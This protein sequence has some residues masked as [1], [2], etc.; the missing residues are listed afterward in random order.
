MP[1]SSIQRMF[2]GTGTR[3]AGLG[4]PQ[5]G[6]GASV[7]SA[8]MR[9]GESRRAEAQKKEDKYLAAMDVDPVVYMSNKNTERQAQLLEEYQKD[10]Q[11]LLKQR[12]N[13]FKNFTTQDWV[14]L[15]QKRRVLEAEQERMTVDLKKFEA[16]DKIMEQDRAGK[17]QFD[18][19]EWV[20]VK[21]QYINEGKFPDNFVLPI[22]AKSFTETIA[23][24]SA[25]VY[26]GENIGG[27]EELKIG[28]VPHKR[29]Y[30]VNI[31]E[32]QAKGLIKDTIL[33]DDAARKDAYNKFNDLSIE[34]KAK[35]LLDEDN[36]KAISTTEEKN[37][38][39][40]W[41]QNNPE[42]IQAAQVRNYGSPTAI[43]QPKGATV[44]PVIAGRQT[45][46]PMGFEIE[47]VKNVDGNNVYSKETVK[48]SKDSFYFPGD[49]KEEIVKGSISTEGAKVF[50]GG[51]ADDVDPGLVDGRLVLYDPQ[52]HVFV[53]QTIA[54]SGSAQTPTKS[55]IEVPEKNVPD[56]QNVIIEM[57]G[58]PMRIGDYKPVQSTTTAPSN[59]W[60]KYLKK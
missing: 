41:A 29:P 38:I 54:A 22:K 19:D 15:Q 50:Q 43:T 40:R 49:K 42:F 25:D 24:K 4:Q 16:V 59:K 12:K 32:G 55:L 18:Y 60:E 9:L 6:G 45:T 52:K 26:K 37:G 28:G 44:K 53:V 58:K 56:Y 33:G 48:Y 46:T 23:K 27:E 39:I 3:P 30:T 17:Q 35:W 21:M 14:Y 57:N 5:V 11:E 36:D 2:T 51:W 13:N 34:E 8:G 7:A 31:S 20:P 1:E 10:A 47:V